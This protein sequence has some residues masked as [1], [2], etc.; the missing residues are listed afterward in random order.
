MPKSEERFILKENNQGT[1]D[2]TDRRLGCSCNK[3]ELDILCTQ[4]SSVLEGYVPP[5]KL[6]RFISKLFS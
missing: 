5:S 3:D 1:W 6:K 2:L 4:L